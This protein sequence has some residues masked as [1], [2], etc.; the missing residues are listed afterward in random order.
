[1]KVFSFNVAAA[2]IVLGTVSA[3]NAQFGEHRTMGHP[4]ATHPLGRLSPFGAGHFESPGRFSTRG[5]HTSPG[6]MRRRPLQSRTTRHEPRER[7]LTRQERRE[8]T[9]S[10]VERSRTRPTTINVAGKRATVVGKPEGVAHDP[11]RTSGKLGETRDH[12]PTII[13]KNDHLYRRSYYEIILD[14]HR[15]WYW[16]DEPSST[17]DAGSPPPAKV[18]VC[19]DE[20]DDCDLG[21]GGPPPPGDV[22]GNGRPPGG[23]NT[24]GELPKKELTGLEKS[25]IE[26]AIKNLE[27]LDQAIGTALTGVKLP[28]KGA[29]TLS[30]KGEVKGPDPTI[31]LKLTLKDIIDKLKKRITSGEIRVVDGLHGGTTYTIPPNTEKHRQPSILIQG[32]GAGGQAGYANPHAFTC[33]RGTKVFNTTTRQWDDCPEGTILIDSTVI[34]KAINVDDADDYERKIE[35]AGLLAHEMAHLSLLNQGD[36]AGVSR[37]DVIST[38]AHKVVYAFQMLIVLAE[39]KLF[40]DKF[41]KAPGKVKT[42]LIEHK[43]RVKRGTMGS[44]T[45]KGWEED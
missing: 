32:D 23:N 41:P 29:T 39:E 7:H 26:I 44:T 20:D 16:W 31:D 37:S 14:R 18:P 15:S 38:E 17:A 42:A 8:R 34:G 43:E 13:T 5:I 19:T 30:P 10:T 45:R 2:L 11:K 35:L 22:G 4:G 3:A 6:T 36:A 40:N 9:R 12:Q 1:M 28:G 24:P 21:G 33:L 25:N 27:Q